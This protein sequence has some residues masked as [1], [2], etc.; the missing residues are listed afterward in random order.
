M[1]L[2]FMLFIAVLFYAYYGFT[3]VRILITL[4]FRTTVEDMVKIERE[5]AK[6]ILNYTDRY[7]AKFFVLLYSF[8]VYEFY[9]LIAAS[10]LTVTDSYLYL[11]L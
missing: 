1:I 8:L 10:Y 9:Y 7:S 3:L 6:T 4:M 2:L 11:Y 5:T